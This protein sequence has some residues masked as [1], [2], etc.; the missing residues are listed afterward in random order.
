MQVNIPPQFKPYLIP[1]V[2]V[3]VSIVGA[4]LYSSV[5]SLKAAKAEHAAAV[6]GVQAETQR[7]YIADLETRVRKGDEEKRVL[8]ETYQHKLRVAESRPVPPPVGKPPVTSP[9]LQNG[10]L[11]LG[12]KPGLVV[13]A[14]PFA[15]SEMALSDAQSAWIWGNEAKRAKALEERIAA[16]DEA[17]KACGDLNNAST[18]QI[19]LRDETIVAIK[20]ESSLS[21]NQAEELG[22]AV[23]AEK[24]KS[25]VQK[26]LWGAAGLGIG[27]LARG[28]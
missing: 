3:L 12:M 17:L 10:L 9:E 2:V 15:H 14:D 22:K 11:D 28:K 1:A 13:V 23:V 20:K 25:T 21:K 5:Q 18:E 4:L 26:W 27:W 7:E 24:K 16:L 19:R 6:L 8:E